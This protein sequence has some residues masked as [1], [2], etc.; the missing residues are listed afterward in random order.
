MPKGN[1]PQ[2][3]NKKE[4]ADFLLHGGILAA[5][6]L[7]VRFIGMLYRIPMVNIIGSEGAGYYSSAYSVYNILLLLSSYSMPLAVS[8]MVSA[9]IA[10]GKWKESKRTLYVA[11]FFSGLMG[12][13]FGLITYFFSDFFCGTILNVPNATFAL[14]FLAPTIAIMGFLGVFRGFF[15]GLQT[16]VP[17]ALS[18]IIEQIIN[19]GVSIGMAY[20]LF[21]SEGAMAD[22]SLKASMGAGGGTIG[23]CA[24]AFA[25]LIFFLIIFFGYRKT[26]EKRV[27][28]D[29]H[30]TIRSRQR[31]LTILIF[32]AVPVVLS[33]VVSNILDI[34][35]SSFFNH[36]MERVG[37]A[38]KEYSAIWGDYSN[39]F[40]LLIHLPIACASSIAVALVPSLSSAFAK[41]DKIA[42]SEK[43]TLSMRVTFLF[44]I[45]C[46]FGMM[47]IGG[48]LAKFL[49]PSIS[50][51]AVRFL[52]VGAP[53]V[54][55]F[56]LMTVT[57]GILQGLNEMG[58]P[59]IHSFIALGVHIALLALCLFVFKW[60]IFA[61]IVL[62]TLF[63]L[64][65]TILNMRAIYRL[66][67]YR[68]QWMKSVLLPV[69][70]SLVMV[71]LCVILSFV[72][73]RFTTGTLARILILF[74]SV[75]VS[76]PLY[77]FGIIYWNCITKEQIQDLPKGNTILRFLKR[78]HFIH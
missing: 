23:T 58:K 47:A 61:V 25:A 70:I 17:T 52:A 3:K 55:T 37:M 14:R 44:S 78:I 28:R 62:Y 8:K 2:K 1:L 77:V 65:V 34:V 76:V 10:N 59:V 30:E 68:I 51:M 22:A 4:D 66:T 43:I 24:G 32:T 21:N 5:A 49:F 6:S 73:T 56:S 53:A 7:I 63:G 64:C 60:N 35:D 45:P 74:F 16:T 12:I 19:A 40:I 46:T 39:A 72:I 71:I 54:M 18:Q 33:T 9:R 41:R 36:A 13:L 42:V 31:L 11:L 38:E 69:F 15:Q 50:D 57:N 67:G 26:F 29:P 75:L 20:V 27:K 48:N